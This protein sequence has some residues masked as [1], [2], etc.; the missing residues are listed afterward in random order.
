MFDSQ[1]INI[2]AVEKL[3]RYLEV[4]QRHYF[5]NSDIT[6]FLFREIIKSSILEDR[7]EDLE[8]EIKEMKEMNNLH[9][10]YLCDRKACANCSWPTC[11]HT[12]NSRH[13]INAGM[14]LTEKDFNTEIVA[15]KNGNTD[16][17][18]VEKEEKEIGNL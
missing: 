16:I 6:F 2:A 5:R 12:S 14:R 7:I 3:E 4:S 9:V 15:G 17:F 11:K 1:Y 13:A 10:L 18:L 8:N